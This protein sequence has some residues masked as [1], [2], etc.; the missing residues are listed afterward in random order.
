M[1]FPITD[2]FQLVKA[3]NLLKQK[4]SFIT[5]DFLEL[6]FIESSAMTSSNVDTAFFKLIS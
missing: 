1:I 3:R 4:V 6:E 2:K 5:T